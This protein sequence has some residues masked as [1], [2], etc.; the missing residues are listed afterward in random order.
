MPPYR[1]LAAKQIAVVKAKAWV[2]LWPDVWYVR[3]YIGHVGSSTNCGIRVVIHCY[4]IQPAV[5]R[6]EKGLIRGQLAGVNG[7]QQ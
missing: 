4:M 5:C 3:L 1:R 7:I 2:R 6:K